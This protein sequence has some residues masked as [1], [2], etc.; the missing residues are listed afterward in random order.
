MTQ[1]DIERINN[2]FKEFE[3]EPLINEKYI[4]NLSESDKDVIERKVKSI[5]S[6]YKIYKILETDI[7]KNSYKDRGLYI[8]ACSKCDEYFDAICKYLIEI[9]QIF[10]EIKKEAERK[11]INDKNAR[12]G[13]VSIRQQLF[14]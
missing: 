11:N 2:Y 1:N 8:D 4:E 3:I 9:N 14:N 5:A 7:D 10:F 12:N 6:K 13:F